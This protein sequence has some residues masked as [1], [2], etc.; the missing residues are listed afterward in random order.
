MINYNQ[1]N[2]ILKENI[3]MALG[4]TEPVAV[5][6]SVAKA[7]EILG[8]KVNRVVLKLSGN[9]I[10][11]A[12]GVGI[13]STDMIGLPIAVALSVVG[14]E[15]YKELQ[16]LDNASSNLVEAKNWLSNH[17]VDI[18]L[19]E[20]S[21]KLYIEAICFNEDEQYFSRAII[22]YSHT[23]F[24]FL[25][26]NEG[27]ILDKNNDSELSEENNDEKLMSLTTDI[28]YNFA[29]TANLDDIRWLLDAAKT[30][31]IASE[32]GL[33]GTYGLKAG[34]L[35]LKD[36]GNSLRQRI[37]AKTVAA[38]DARMSGAKA[39]VYSNFGSGN[40]GITCSLPVLL[41]AKEI[42]ASEEETIRGLTLSNLMSI[43]IKS[44]IGRL[45]A[46]CGIVNASIGV[47]SSIVFLQ[48][49]TLN[50]IRFAINNM[51]NTI[52][53]M[54]CDG[55]K[56]SCALKI[57]AGLNSAF[58]SALLALNNICVDK[59][60]GIASPDADKSILTL[61]EIGRNYMNETDKAI[62]HIMVNK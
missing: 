34:Y 1:I 52:T 31:L 56:P 54:I 6:L 38:S 15:S 36:E 62:L 48:K 23:N 20:T 51:I 60:D 59:T 33:K 39:A 49:G 29:K 14:G 8:K 27:I 57:S 21:E 12:M 30:N 26:N 46:L 7:K 24:I 47:A 5:A 50:Q 44:H 3:I 32:E 40:Q 22:K 16:V 2:D 28:V 37:I 4:C 35:I 17:K 58:D 41:F 18:Q 13:P 11:N 19:K 43:Y 9:V 61:G 55:A 10:K 25:E 53:G 45:S 42:N